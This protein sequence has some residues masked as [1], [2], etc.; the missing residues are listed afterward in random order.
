MS[1]DYTHR[2]KFG[3][4]AT[5][6]GRWS[7]F[8][9]REPVKRRTR[10]VTLEGLYRHPIATHLTF[11]GLALY[12]D[13]SDTLSGDDEG[14]DVDLSLEWTIRQTEVRVTYELGRIE[15]NFA[16]S[17]NTALYVQLRRRF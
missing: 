2:F 13:E 9:H 15:D 4:V 5:I 3:A 16:K 11:E 7:R 1:A 17:D 6:K 10:L 14:I 8:E 12:R